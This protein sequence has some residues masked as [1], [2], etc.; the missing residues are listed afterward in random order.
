MGDYPKGGITTGSCPKG[1]Y[2]QL[3]ATVRWGWG[4]TNYYNR[5]GAHTGGSPRSVASRGQCMRWV[6]KESIC[7][8]TFL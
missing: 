3:F 5:K 4:N 2:S 7:A 1:K 6:K 8:P